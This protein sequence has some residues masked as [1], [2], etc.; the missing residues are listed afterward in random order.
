M[1][2]WS[3]WFG[4]IAQRREQ[5]RSSPDFGDMGTAF[6]LDA[7]MEAEA[8]QPLSWQAHAA[9]DE[10]GVEPSPPPRIRP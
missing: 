5:A 7:S 1:K 8:V 3:E 6:G 10:S 9:Q 4:A 2:K